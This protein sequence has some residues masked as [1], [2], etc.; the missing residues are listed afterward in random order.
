MAT[1]NALLRAADFSR[2]A[3]G[4]SALNG[5]S[6]TVTA[7]KTLAVA[8][9]PERFPSQV[10]FPIVSAA[11]LLRR[12][13]VGAAQHKPRFTLAPFGTSCAAAGMHCWMGARR[14]TGRSTEHIM[15]VGGAG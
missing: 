15:A 14:R 10:V 5:M 12:H 7:A 13:T 8:S 2:T 4:V 9:Q 11:T 1:I 6:R 3:G